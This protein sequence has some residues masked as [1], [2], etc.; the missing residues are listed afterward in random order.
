MTDDNI[1]L[2]Y[3]DYDYSPVAVYTEDKG[4]L[5]SGDNIH[6]QGYGEFAEGYGM[7][8]GRPVELVYIDDMDDIEE[9]AA[10]M[11]KAGVYDEFMEITP[12]ERLIIDISDTGNWY[13]RGEKD[14]ET[15]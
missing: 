7:A 6:N 15:R 2:I 11:K 13:T 14:E 9:H 5:F 1:Y 8:S 4:V 3:S 12:S 10:L